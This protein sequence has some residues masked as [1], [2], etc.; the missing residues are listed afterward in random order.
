MIAST[1]FLSI[2]G[3]MQGLEFSPT[4]FS[5]KLVLFGEAVLIL[6]IWVSWLILLITPRQQTTVTPPAKPPERF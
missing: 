4:F 6:A 2:L 5:S 1:L 3:I